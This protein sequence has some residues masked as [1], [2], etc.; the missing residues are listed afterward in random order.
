M[1]VANRIAR[2]VAFCNVA[3]CCVLQRENREKQVYAKDFS[4]AAHRIRELDRLQYCWRVCCNLHRTDVLCNTTEVENN[5][6]DCVF[7]R[8]FLLTHLKPYR[9]G[10]LDDNC[11]RL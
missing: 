11:V 6:A 10:G 2:R 3:I 8:V 9:V 5:S 4:R 7:R 1:S